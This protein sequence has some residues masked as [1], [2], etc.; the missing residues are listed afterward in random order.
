[1]IISSQP[2][3]PKEPNNDTQKEVILKACTLLEKIHNAIINYVQQAGPKRT[4]DSTIFTAVYGLLDLI[5]LE[6]VYPSLTPG[7]CSSD[8]RLAKSILYPK[9]VQTSA[10][11]PDLQLLESMIYDVLNP[12][13]LAHDQGVQPML[14]G[15]VV[16]DLVAANAELAL[17][18]RRSAGE[19]TRELSELQNLLNRYA[20]MA[21]KGLIFWLG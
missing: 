21:W 4:L 5:I 20:A 2:N 12:I 15:R 17:S 8:Q 16:S 1:V 14:Q 6:G 7:I 19:K 3:A 9:G 18:P 10:E 13:A 11:P